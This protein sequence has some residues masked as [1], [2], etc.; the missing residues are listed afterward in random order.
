MLEGDDL[1]T[2]GGSLVDRSQRLE[3]DLV[4]ILW[5]LLHFICSILDEDEAS[6]LLDQHMP[7]QDIG[8]CVRGLDPLQQPSILVLPRFEKAHDTIFC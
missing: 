6:L 4:R 3:K 8:Q 5:R 1:I 7:L 2:A